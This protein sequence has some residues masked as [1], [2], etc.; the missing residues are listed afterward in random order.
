MGVTLPRGPPKWTP[1]TSIF[2][3]AQIRVPVCVDISRYLTEKYFDIVWGGIPLETPPK[4]TPQKSIFSTTQ[5]R[6]SVFF[7]ISRDLTDKDFG[8]VWACHPLGNPP[9]WTPQ[10][11]FFEWPK[12]GCQRFMILGNI[13]TVLFWRFHYQIFLNNCL[14]CGRQKVL[15]SVTA[16]A[17]RRLFTG[18]DGKLP[19]SCEI[20]LVTFLAK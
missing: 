10:N 1:K 12:L 14:F 11:N 8:E 20:E 4:W 15:L 17:M 13:L 9:K 18:F 16:L 7:D 5:L 19:S 3:M 2:W 6:V